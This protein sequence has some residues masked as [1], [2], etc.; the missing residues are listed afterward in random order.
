[1]GK[2]VII[3]QIYPN[4]LY[5]CLMPFLT[6]VLQVR[7][8]AVSEASAPAMLSHTSPGSEFEPCLSSGLQGS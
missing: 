1:M 5:V 8:L 4:H 3:W 2:P 6:T 7:E